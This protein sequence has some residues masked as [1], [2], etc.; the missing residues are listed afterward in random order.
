MPF[1]ANQCAAHIKS[2]EKINQLAC[3]LG[4]LERHLAES[5]DYLDQLSAL[6][7]DLSQEVDGYESVIVALAGLYRQTDTT[8]VNTVVIQQSDDGGFTTALSSHEPVNVILAEPD[9]CGESNLT[10]D[11]NECV[12]WQVTTDVN[13]KAVRNIVSTRK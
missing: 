7:V 12:S 1:P 5:T 10:I 3:I 11:G 2:D 6:G 13:D 8:A 4:D 9:L